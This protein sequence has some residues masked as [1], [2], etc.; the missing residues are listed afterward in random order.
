MSVSEQK[1]NLAGIKSLRSS[2]LAGLVAEDVD[3]SSPMLEVLTLD[4]TDLD[5]DAS[6]FLASCSSL[7][8]L[9]LAGTKFTSA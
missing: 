5:D 7:R 8:I 3:L 1:L 4:N 6:A 2:D 9:S